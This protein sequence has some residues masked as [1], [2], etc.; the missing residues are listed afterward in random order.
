MNRTFFIFLLLSQSVMANTDFLKDAP[1][2]WLIADTLQHKIY[3]HGHLDKDDQLIEEIFSS[4]QY[5]K[6]NDEIILTS[7]KKTYALQKNLIQHLEK[8]YSENNKTSKNQK[9]F[10]DQTPI[11]EVTLYKTN[12]KLKGHYYFNHIH[13]D[14]SQDNSSLKWL[15][16]TPKETY[17]RLDNFLKRRKMQGTVAFT[18]HDTDIAFDRVAPIK[19]DRL[20]ILRGVEWGGK[21]HMCLIGIKENWDNLPNGREYTGEESVRQS[22]SS[23]GFRIINHPNRKTPFPYTSWLGVDGVEVWNTALENSPFLRLDLKR[24]DNRNAFKQ[25][26]NS[27]KDN[28]N[29]TAVAGSDFH[30]M[31]PCFS[32]RTLTYPLN[33]IPTADTSQ[34]KAYLK[35]GRSSFLTRPDAP[36][37]TL[38]AKFEGE[39]SWTDMGGKISGQGNL[40]VQLYGD[41]SD[42]RKKI[43]GVCYNI[44]NSFY[45]TLTFW[46]KRFWEIRFFNQNGD[47]VGKR[48]INPKWYNYKKHFKATLSM[49]IDNQDTIRAE[50]WSVNNKTDFLDLL[51]ATNP[52]YINWKK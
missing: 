26:H 19:N 14:I 5:D 23:D 31:I 42:S 7:N 24:S 35:E 21:T 18:D 3:E 15:K 38:Q 17:S 36:K 50:L 20:N 2:E 52:I 4:I 8:K 16:L 32:E 44:V 11:A 43:G 37:L 46:K 29:Y 51:G 34:T 45:R 49:P 47:L 33:F 39:E 9:T 12:V 40:E 28:K 41:F 13:T 1:L 6:I 30:F 27:I 10:L 48:K 25:W 22:R